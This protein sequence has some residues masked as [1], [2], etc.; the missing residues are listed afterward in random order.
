MAKKSSYLAGT[1]S[2]CDHMSPDLEGAKA[3]YGALFG[4]TF[5]GGGSEYSGYTTCLMD[6]AQVAGLV[7]QSGPMVGSP[8]VW[9]TYFDSKDADATCAAIKAHGGTVMYEPM[10]V[11]PLGRMAVAVDPTGGAFGLWQA[12]VHTGSHMFGEPG[13]M[14]WHELRTRDLKAAVE[15]YAAAL[16]NP[17]EKMPA[18]D[19]EYFVAKTP[20]QIHA[21]IMGMPAHMP[22]ETPPHWLVYFA[23]SDADAVAA[24][25]V[26]LGGTLSGDPVDTP[27]GRTGFAAD[28]WGARFAYVQTRS[29]G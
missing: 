17:V 4:W 24:K 11:G 1:P 20:G 12:K 27:H 13:S 2:W 8:S 7:P 19:M 26:A 5:A 22:A 9:S 16:G 6:G 3:F 21:G 25:V 10:D 23:V 14:A 18:G 29:S 15:F 28:T